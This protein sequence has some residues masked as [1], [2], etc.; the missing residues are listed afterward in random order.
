MTKRTACLVAFAAGHLFLVACGAAG[1]GLLPEGTG[2]EKALRCYGAMTGAD[3]TYGFFA[4]DVA[5]EARGFLTI[6]DPDGRSW[7]EPVVEGD[8]EEVRL[9]LSSMYGVAAGG[10]QRRGLAAS[11]AARAFGRHPEA[12]VITV[13]IDL[14]EVPTMEDYRDGDRPEFVTI[15]ERSFVRGEVLAAAQGGE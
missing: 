8:N 10:E 9:R 4:P 7:T 1:F 6:T 2:A 15:Y 11:W 13:R 14:Y 3:N 5:E 12:R